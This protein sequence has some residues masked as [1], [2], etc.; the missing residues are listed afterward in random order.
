[1]T[2][3]TQR[4]GRRSNQT[5]RPRLPPGEKRVKV[6]IVMTPAHYAAT[7]GNRS[8]KIERALNQMLETGNAENPIKE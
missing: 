1:M 5:G 3:K 4:G 2:N 7:A 6:S 8:A